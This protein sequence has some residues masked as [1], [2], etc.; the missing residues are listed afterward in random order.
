M[1]TPTS[2]KQREAGLQLMNLLSNTAIDGRIKIMSLGEIQSIQ[3]VVSLIIDDAVEKALERFR[4]EN[5]TTALTKAE[6][7]PNEEIKI[8][9]TQDV[10]DDV[11]QDDSQGDGQ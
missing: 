7:L 4:N 11:L 10:L 6:G 1:T 9:S 2:S 5:R 8:N 3:A